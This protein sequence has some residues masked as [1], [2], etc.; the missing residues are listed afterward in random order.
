MCLSVIIQLIFTEPYKLFAIIC[1]HFPEKESKTK[2]T[3]T[4]TGIGTQICLMLVYHTII[5]FCSH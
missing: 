3:N 5:Y 4:R 2:K 1:S